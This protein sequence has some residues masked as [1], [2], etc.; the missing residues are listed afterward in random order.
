MLNKFSNINIGGTCNNINIINNY[1]YLIKKVCENQQKKKKFKVIGS[2]TNIYF[3][4]KYDGE[5]IVNKCKEIIKT[6]YF[7]VK[8]NEKIENNNELFIVSSGT[9]LMDLVRFYERESYDISELSYIPG[10]V[11]G[12]IYNNAGAYGLEISDILIGANIINNGSI[13]YYSNKDFEFEYRNSI[14]KK[15]KMNIVIISAFFKKH[16]KKE[17]EEIKKNI[18]KIIKIR[19]NKLPYEFHNIGSIFKNICLGNIK[20]STGMLLEK[21]NINKFSQ[22]NLKIYKKHNNI[23]INEGLAKPE[24]LDNLLKKIQDEFTYKYGIKLILE[25]EKIN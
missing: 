7:P 19:K 6:K 1:N 8:Y 18:E 12:A 13:Q 24:D 21:I 15:N 20:L 2:G 11:G 4:E 23:I 16:I 25:I 10:T 5:I 14:L 9:I 17:K 3:G 22:N